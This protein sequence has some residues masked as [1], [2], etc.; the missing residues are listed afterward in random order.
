[1]R[2]TRFLKPF[3]QYL[4]RG[5]RM[6]QPKK[7]AR[8]LELEG[9]EDRTVPSILFDNLTSATT[10]DNNGPVINHV[11]V[12]LIFWGADWNTGSNPTLRR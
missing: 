8:R 1:M 12:E 3:R 4:S 9:L 5:P 10:G 11:H 7:L 2:F 6:P